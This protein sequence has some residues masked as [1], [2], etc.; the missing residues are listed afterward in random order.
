V[1]TSQLK[2][3]RIMAQCVRM[4]LGARPT[5]SMSRSTAA[6][7]VDRTV[8]GNRLPIS[9]SHQ[10]AH[11][12][13]SLAAVDSAPPRPDP[14]RYDR[15]PLPLGILPTFKPLVASNSSN[16]NVRRSIAQDFGVVSG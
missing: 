3:A 16:D 4:V 11:W 15:A 5:V 12:A 2:N 1:A 9:T 10:L 14:K 6:R 8:C 7:S 13:R